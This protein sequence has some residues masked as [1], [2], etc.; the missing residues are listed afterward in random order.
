MKEK[1]G[2]TMRLESALE[3]MKEEKKIYEKRI[4]ELGKMN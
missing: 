4:N 3:Q 1:E 2:L